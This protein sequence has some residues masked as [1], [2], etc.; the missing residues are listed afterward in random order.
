MIFLPT[1]KKNFMTYI[2]FNDIENLLGS[3][4]YHLYYWTVTTYII[5]DLKNAL[6]LYSLFMNA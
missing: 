6:C 1:F 3:Q 2:L 4:N 5:N